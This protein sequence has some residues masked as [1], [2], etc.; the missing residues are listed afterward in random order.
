V[1]CA[2]LDHAWPWR[3][4]SCVINVDCHKLKCSRL[5]VGFALLVWKCN[6][7]MRLVFTGSLSNLFVDWLRVLNEFLMIN[8]KCRYPDNFVSIDEKMHQWIMLIYEF[9][10]SESGECVCGGLGCDATWTCNWPPI[11]QRKIRRQYVP[12][13]RWC[14]P[15]HPC[16]ITSQKTI[17]DMFVYMNC[18]VKGG[19]TFQLPIS[20]W[21]CCFKWL[22]T[23]F[24]ILDALDPNGYIM[25]RLVRDATHFVDGHHVKDLECL[26]RDL[27]KV[28]PPWYQGHLP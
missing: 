25:Y 6:D 28:R 19:F 17:I 2:N 11:I 3:S 4:P 23:V 12:P 8:L 16:S 20:S 15:T 21:F 22:Q 24:P 9:L 13:E 14:P 7:M 5:K 10:G 26:N 18:Y 27:R 1:A